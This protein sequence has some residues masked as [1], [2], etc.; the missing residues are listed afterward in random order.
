MP[1]ENFEKYNQEAET[2]KSMRKNE[3]K[4]CGLKKI[5][6]PTKMDGPEFSRFDKNGRQFV[7]ATDFF[8]RS[9]FSNSKA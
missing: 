4:V 2:D 7:S 1:R 3:F 6:R 5:D 8:D 9:I